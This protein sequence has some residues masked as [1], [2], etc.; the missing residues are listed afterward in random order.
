MYLLA[1]MLIS[2]AMVAPETRQETVLSKALGV[3]ARIESDAILKATF[4]DQDGPFGSVAFKLIVNAKVKEKKDLMQAGVWESI[5]TF[6]SVEKFD[7]PIQSNRSSRQESRSLSFHVEMHD[8]RTIRAMVFDDF[9][10]GSFFGVSSMPPGS[11]V[12]WT[13]GE[14]TRGIR[15]VFTRLEN[16]KWN[17]DVELFGRKID[18]K[19]VRS[20]SG[21]LDKHCLELPGVSSG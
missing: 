14:S 1:M 10:P 19:T 16:G 8:V 9:D 15:F 20:L 2:C 6:V 5:F 7:M 18:S 13:G 4:L 21:I 11:A 17:R 3:T 12:V